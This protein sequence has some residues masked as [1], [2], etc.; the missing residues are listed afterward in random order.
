MHIVLLRYK[1]P[2][3]VARWRDE[4]PTPEM[5]LDLERLLPQLCLVYPHI[6]FRVDCA[7]SFIQRHLKP[8]VASLAGIYGCAAAQRILAIAPDGSVFPCSQLVQPCF[9]AG[10]IR[11]DDP[12]VLWSQA[13]VL[14]TYRSFRD[15][16][17]FRQSQCGICQASKHCGG[18]RVFAHDAPGSRSGLPRPAQP[19]V[20]LIRKDWPPC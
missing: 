1:P 18:C 5:L 2:A 4:K 17:P 15:K 13:K 3:K 12:A 6:Q 10:N 11:H 8:D 20:A 9:H 19:A 16:T 7:L 14:R